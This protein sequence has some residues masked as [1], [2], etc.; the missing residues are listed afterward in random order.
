MT[1]K[2]KQIKRPV[3]VDKKGEATGQKPGAKD[4]VSD[5]DGVTG[6]MDALQRKTKGKSSVN[7]SLDG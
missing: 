1:K 6:L 7:V 5:H 4:Q 3:K 2:G